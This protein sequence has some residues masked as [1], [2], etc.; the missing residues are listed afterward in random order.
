VPDILTK[1]A[2]LELGDLLIDLPPSPYL[3]AFS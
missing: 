3:A 2:L 1:I